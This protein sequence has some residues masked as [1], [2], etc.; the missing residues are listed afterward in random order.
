ML[1]LMTIG[2]CET[3]Q[4]QGKKRKKSNFASFGNPFEK[5]FL[6]TQWWLGFIVGG[7]LTQAS[8][9]TRFS[10]FSPNNF[11]TN[12][13]DKEYQSYNQL[14]GQAGIEITFYHNGLS[15]TIQPNY[16]RQIFTYSNEYAWFDGGNPTNRLELYYQQDHKLDFVE[17]PLLFKYDFTRGAIRPYVQVG[18]Y[19]G[20]LVNATKSVDIS[21]ADF[22]SGGQDEFD[23]GSLVI[24]ADD[25]FIK[26]SLGLMGGVGLSYDVWNVRMILEAHYRHGLNN[27]SDAE[28]R[29]T[30][31]QLAGIGDALDDI[32]LRNISINA[33][34]LFPLRFISKDFDTL[35]GN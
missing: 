32:Q 30:N 10:A 12:M 23:G 18:G 2:L 14:G 34:I 31:N 9:T 25:L 26:S 7:N 19:Y 5:S 16:R 28:N 15:V 24:G 33:G 29:Y 35:D 13:V 3:A 4:A 8:P 17:L 20:V 1:I 27:I 11:S 22:A 21:G 6:Q